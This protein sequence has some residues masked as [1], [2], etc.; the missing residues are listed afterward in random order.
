MGY[1]E[2]RGQLWLE[3]Y[4]LAET[5]QKQIPVFQS[6][7]QLIWKG[8]MIYLFST[9]PV[10][11]DLPPQRQLSSHHH[12]MK[13]TLLFFLS[14]NK[15][16]SEK[17]ANC[18]WSEVR[19]WGSGLWTWFFLFLNLCLFPC[20]LRA[21]SRDFSLHSHQCFSEINVPFFQSHTWGRVSGPLGEKSIHQYAAEKNTGALLTFPLVFVNIF[22]KSPGS[23]T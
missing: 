16:G 3:A 20:I 9:W 14:D 18:Q 17:S 21:K 15:N 8:M 11:G 13:N 10:P 19:T 23:T 1:L 12:S 6:D 5:N 4:D 2:P 7:K 22:W